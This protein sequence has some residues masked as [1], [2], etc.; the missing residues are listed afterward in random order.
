MFQATQATRIKQEGRIGPHQT[1]VLDSGP[2]AAGPSL[3]K[4]IADEPALVEGRGVAVLRA[5]HAGLEADKAARLEDL[6][7]LCFRAAHC[8]ALHRLQGASG[9]PPA[10][11]ELLGPLVRRRWELPPPGY[12]GATGGGSSG[13]SHGGAIS[14]PG[15]PG[16]PS[17]L[18]SSSSSGMGAPTLSA[19]EAM[20]PQGPWP[21]LRAR[22]LVDQDCRL[23][24]SNRA[25]YLRPSAVN[26][27]RAGVPDPVQSIAVAAAAGETAL[28]GPVPQLGALHGGATDGSGAPMGASLGAAGPSGA[29]A[30]SGS[31]SSDAAAGNR[32]RHRDLRARLDD[33]GASHDAVRA[34]ELAALE[35]E[36]ASSGGAGA[37]GLEA[38]SGAA[39]GQWG[40]AKLRVGWENVR[41]L[42]RRTRMRRDVGLELELLPSSRDGAGSGGMGLG[43]GMGG[44]GLGMGGGFGDG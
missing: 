3:G 18:S 19:G 32:N 22:P 15:E 39:G 27:P 37:G 44:A 42:R 12:A 40:G 14:A 1:V 17:S 4:D 9:R 16:G 8:R 20:L 31:E 38:G 6:L 21:V 29:P 24:L 43:M 23:F 34:G 2:D 41:A 10:E 11:D 33:P 36:R 13:A 7:L 28:L 30:G 25:L 26:C 35:G 5:G